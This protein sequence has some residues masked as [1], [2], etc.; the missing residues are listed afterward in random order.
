M[1]ESIAG[2]GLIADD[3]EIT[4]DAYRIKPL[5]WRKIQ[6]RSFMPD[7]S[8]HIVTYHEAEAIIKYKISAFTDGDF[9]ATAYIPDQ[10][11]EDGYLESS[12]EQSIEAAKEW[13]NLYHVNYLLQALERI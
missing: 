2:N 9:K 10:G 1:S 13:C 3:G 4:F 11:I 7:G 8:P 5:V 12:F 6:Y